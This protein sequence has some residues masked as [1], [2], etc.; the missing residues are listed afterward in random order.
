MP[1][2]FCRGASWGS[3][4]LPSVLSP[5]LSR[6]DGKP[7]SGGRSETAGLQRPAPRAR[8][9]Q[10]RPAPWRRLAAAAVRRLGRLPA[11]PRAG[12]RLAAG[13]A[14]VATVQPLSRSRARGRRRRPRLLCGRR[15]PSEPPLCAPGCK[16][17]RVPPESPG[18]PAGVAVPGRT[19]AAPP[20]SARLWARP[21]APT[22]GPPSSRPRPC[23]HLPRGSS[24]SLAR[25]LARA[26]AAERFPVP[27]RGSS[28]FPK[29]RLCALKQVAPTWEKQ[30]VFADVG[31]GQK[32]PRAEDTIKGA[33]H[34]F[35]APTSSFAHSP[36]PCPR[37]TAPSA[38]TRAPR[39][40][41]S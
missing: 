9:L 41:S 16:W 15:R 26:R 10:T 37:P 20:P 6:R 31:V 29:P 30:K 34:R 39:F 23:S 21:A 28:P 8:R 33:T 18:A 35:Q 12:P 1:G 32:R 27:G 2:T 38:G 36:C 7:E 5:E 3:I 13:R 24:R 40:P 11:F 17:R 14:R 22:P 4:F 19:P 25:S